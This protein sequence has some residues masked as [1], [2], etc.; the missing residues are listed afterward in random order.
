MHDAPT[1]GTRVLIKATVFGFVPER[2]GSSFRIHKPVGT[3]WV[4]CRFHDGRWQEWCGTAN[5]QSTAAIQPIDWAPLPEG[6]E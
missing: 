6:K 2:H 3:R 5:R 4:E 1:D